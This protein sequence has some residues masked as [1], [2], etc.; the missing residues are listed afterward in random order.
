MEQWSKLFLVLILLAGFFA[1]S[2]PGRSAEID[3]DG[4]ASLTR[5]SGDRGARTDEL[6]FRHLALRGIEILEK[7][8]LACGFAVDAERINDASGDQSSR[9]YCEGA[10]HDSSYDIHGYYRSY[11]TAARICFDD[12]RVGAA[13]LEIET[14]RIGDDGFEQ[15][16]SVREYGSKCDDWEDWAACDKGMLATG[17]KG[18]FADG[19]LR[20]LSLY[21]RDV[22]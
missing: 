6:S 16:R 22:R 4:S 5:I 2:L 11:I 21:C 17:I 19:Y 15:E 18:Q 10:R 9:V 12:K 8:G 3:P 13:G 1:V 7:N 14:V 20:G